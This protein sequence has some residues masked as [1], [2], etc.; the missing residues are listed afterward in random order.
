MP[1]FQL[2]PV[3]SSNSGILVVGFA[4]G[5]IS[6]AVGVMLLYMAIK[7]CDL[8]VPESGRLKRYPLWMGRTI[9]VFIGLLGLAIGA[10]LI[11]RSLRVHFPIRHL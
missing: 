4:L 11:L 9:T 2:P 6:I 8:H 1:L 7:S 10:V 3:H 5:V